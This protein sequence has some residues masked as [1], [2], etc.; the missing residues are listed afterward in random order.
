MTRTD[1]LSKFNAILLDQIV[2]K[3]F[4]FLIIAFI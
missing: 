3:L 1:Y 4:F 2:K